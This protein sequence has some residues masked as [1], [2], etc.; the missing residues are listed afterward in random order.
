MTIKMAKLVTQQLHRERLVAH[1]PDRV[2]ADRAEGAVVAEA[3]LAALGA[4]AAAAASGGDG[5]ASMSDT[6]ASST[7]Q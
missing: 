2:A 5:G 7:D 1:Q 4:A 6:T 3:G